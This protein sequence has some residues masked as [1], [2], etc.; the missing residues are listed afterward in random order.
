[1]ITLAAGGGPKMIT[2]GEDAQGD[3]GLRVS[4]FAGLTTMLSAFGLI[5]QQD[6]V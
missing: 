2:F 5:R 1:M 4:T 6:H 3:H